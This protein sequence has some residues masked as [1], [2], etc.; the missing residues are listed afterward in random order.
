MGCYT[1]SVGKENSEDLPRK[2]LDH[3]P[4]ILQIEFNKNPEKE[5][6]KRRDIQTIEETIKDKDS[7]D[8]AL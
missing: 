6:I 3:N 7:L 5:N 8:S 4:P 2:S 1:S